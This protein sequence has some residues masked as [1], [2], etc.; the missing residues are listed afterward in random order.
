MYLCYIDESGTPQVPGNT[1]HFV[2]CGIAIPIWHWRDVEQEITFALKPYGLDQE[3]FHTAWLI[4]PYFEQSKIANFSNLTWSQ[5]R[6]AVNLARNTYLLRLQKE[7]KQKLY[8]QVK[9]NYKHT[10]SYIHLTYEERRS[11]VKKIADLISHWG[12]A[13]L[14]AECIDKLYFDPVK[15]GRSIDEQA[16]E[17]V[18]SRFEQWIT[19]QP[20]P[21]APAHQNFALIVHDMNPSMAAK[22]SKL[23]QQFLKSGTLWTKIKHIVETPFFVDSRLTRM[24]QMADVCAWALRRFCENGET[25]LFNLVFT[26]A[27]RIKAKVVGVRHYAKQSC[28]CQI[29]KEHK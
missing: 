28:P 8:K 24:V 7:N 23:M 25:E 22:H 18:I 17:Q 1:S 19:R 2:L 5:R 9:K 13:R 4:R 26:R 6:I 21:S 12:F 10:A 29:C 14:F 15:T 3:E 16:F 27:D 11:A 20:P